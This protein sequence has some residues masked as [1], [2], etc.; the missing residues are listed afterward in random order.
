MPATPKATPHEFSAPSPARRPARACEMT[1]MAAGVIALAMPAVEEVMCCWA[2]GST[3]K[4]AANWNTPNRAMAAKSPEGN[5]RP[6]TGRQHPDPASG[7]ADRDTQRRDGERSD[8]PQQ[9]LVEGERD[10]EGSADR[11]KDQPVARRHH[12]DLRASG[13]TRFRGAQG[14][15]AATIAAEWRGMAACRRSPGPARAAAIQGRQSLE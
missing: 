6:A 14:S 4:G 9:H 12:H 7:G 11:H 10:A 3:A 8:R 2:S 1:T 15:G 5:R 13:T